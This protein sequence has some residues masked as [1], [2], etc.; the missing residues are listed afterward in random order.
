MPFRRN[1]VTNVGLVRL[2]RR[3]RLCC[4]VEKLWRRFALLFAGGIEPNPGSM[5]KAQKEK[6]TEVLTIVQ[7]LDIDQASGLETI[8]GLTS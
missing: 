8:R 7:K 2:A 1:V 5:L 4:S 3:K 6:L